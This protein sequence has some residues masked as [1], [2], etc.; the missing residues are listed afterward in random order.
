VS[1]TVVFNGRGTNASDPTG[2]A[3]LRRLI[4]RANVVDG[5]VGTVPEPGSLMLVLAAAAGALIA[6]RRRGAV[7]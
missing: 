6:R 4:I 7:H 5:T 2:L 3:Q 1:D